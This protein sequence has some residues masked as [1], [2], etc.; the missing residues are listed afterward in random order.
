MPW[1]P[2]TTGVAPAQPTDDASSAADNRVEATVAPADPSPTATSMAPLTV[3]D[4]D[5]PADLR[6]TAA[7]YN[8][9]FARA[10]AVNP[11]L[12]TAIRNN[13][14]LAL[15]AFDGAP[16]GTSGRGEL[17]GFVYGFVGRDHATGEVY[18][19]SQTAAVRSDQRGRGVGRLLKLA[20]RDRVLDQGIDRM[21]WAFDPHRTGNAQFNLDIL[22][23]T[24]RWFY[25]NLY[26]SESVAGQPARPSDRLIL[27]WDLVASRDGSTRPYPVVGDPPAWGEGAADGDDLLLALPRT[28]ADPLSDATPPEVAAAVAAVLQDAIS[29]GYQAVSCLPSNDSTAVYRLR[30][31]V[32]QVPQPI[33]TQEP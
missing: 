33:P 24:G 4:L 16:D 13:G 15:G 11:R 1:F 32:P 6:A 3:R 2:A 7:L 22:G 28:P 23:A 29:D 10:D 20:Q 30:R 12:L 9:V 26:G 27:D 31:A 17:V 25:G 19:Y 14:G 8:E 21:R 5:S 18:H